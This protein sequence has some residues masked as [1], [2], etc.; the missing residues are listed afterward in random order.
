MGFWLYKDIKVWWEYILT[1]PSFNDHSTVKR[2]IGVVK[3]A[4]GF[5]GRDR[6]QYNMNGGNFDTINGICTCKS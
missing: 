2:I 4:E 1:F 3:I 6:S 5:Y